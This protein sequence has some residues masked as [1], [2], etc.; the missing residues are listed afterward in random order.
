MNIENYLPELPESA[1]DNDND[2]RQLI[3]FRFGEP[4]IKLGD[5][6]SLKD[7]RE[8]CSSEDTRG[9]GWFVGFDRD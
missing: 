5:P 3:L 8:Y 6:V 7:A 1:D 9:D 4:A 2:A